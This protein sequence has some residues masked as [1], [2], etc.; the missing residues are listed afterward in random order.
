MLELLGGDPEFHEP[1]SEP[2]HDSLV[3]KLSEGFKMVDGCIVPR[4]FQ[5]TSIWS[6]ERPKT[7][8]I[9][10]ETA[11][12]CSLSKVY[13]QD[14]VDKNIPLA[15][16]ARIGCAY[17]MYL[18]KALLESQVSGSFRIIVDAQLPEPEPLVGTAACSVRFHKVRPNQVWLDDNLESYKL[19]ALGVFEF[20]KKILLAD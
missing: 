11:F 19:N 8:N 13:M 10:D 4:S 1:N 16:L 7:N 14:F 3:G 17:A 12:E 18:R 5:A 2:V 6:G 15:G 9:D 20:E